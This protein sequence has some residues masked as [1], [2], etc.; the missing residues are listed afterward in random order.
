MFLVVGWFLGMFFGL[1]V[2]GV[3]CGLI[4]VLV[5]FDFDWLSEVF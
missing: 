3:V 4:S 2:I 5:F 1:V